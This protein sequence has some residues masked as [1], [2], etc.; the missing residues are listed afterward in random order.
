[1][2][3]AATRV[4]SVRIESTPVAGGLLVVLARAAGLG[5]VE[6]VETVTPGMACLTVQGTVPAGQ[7]VLTVEMAPASPAA[8]ARTAV[9]L[10]ITPVGGGAWDEEELL[11][12]AVLDTAAEWLDQHG[13]VWRWTSDRCAPEAWHCGW[14]LTGWTHPVPPAGPVAAWRRWSALAVD[15]AGVLAAQVLVVLAV[16]GLLIHLAGPGRLRPGWTLDVLWAAGEL[17]AAA[18]LLAAGLLVRR[19]LGAVALVVDPQDYPVRR[20]GRPARRGAAARRCGGR[21]GRG[22]AVMSSP[23]VCDC[24]GC[25][26]PAVVV[27][28]DLVGGRAH[29]CPACHQDALRCGGETR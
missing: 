27:I 4:R 22:V 17:P 20:A 25:T 14:R 10:H 9:Y 2:T 8:S 28:A 26:A 1:M 21:P 23:V 3:A 29:A 11:L 7:T 13:A 6:P 18:A 5:H 12:S 15:W 24:P 19:L 16:A